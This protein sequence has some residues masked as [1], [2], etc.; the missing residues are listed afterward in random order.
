[1]DRGFLR[2]VNNL[3]YNESICFPEKVFNLGSDVFPLSKIPVESIS[4]KNRRANRLDQAA[5][6]NL[7]KLLI[8][9]TLLQEQSVLQTRLSLMIHQKYSFK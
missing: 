9:I 7:I 8:E 2:T 6:S 5:V 4:V 1:M 3:T